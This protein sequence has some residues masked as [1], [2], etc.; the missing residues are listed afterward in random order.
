MARIYKHRDSGIYYIDFLHPETGKRIRRSLKTTKKSDAEKIKIRIET[1]I[2]DARY[3]DKKFSN[4]DLTL[5]EFWEQHYKPYIK[6]NNKL[7]TY[8]DKCKKINIIYEAFGND[9]PLSKITTADIERFKNNRKNMVSA[10]TV[11]RNLSLIKHIFSLAVHLELIFDNPAKKVR[12]FS[13]NNSRIRYL[14]VE[15]AERLLGV[16]KREDKPEYIYTLV[17]LALNSGMRRGELLN[18]TWDDIEIEN[19]LIHIKD[20]KNNEPRTI[21]IPK[22]VINVIDSLPRICDNIFCYRGKPVKEP[23]D[24]FRRCLKEANISDFR[25]HDLRHT[26]ASWLA[27]E[28]VDMLTLKNLLGHKTLIMVSRYTHLSKEHMKSAVEKIGK[29][30]HTY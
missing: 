18:L 13:E 5:F 17:L 21:Y 22:E 25:F 27:M 30:W 26:Y 19:N 11:N 28:G 7:S 23:K 9:T 6:A 12:K 10:S 16:C 24:T 8:E 29:K 14:T 4:E 2:W 3:L 15:E 20:S 1:G